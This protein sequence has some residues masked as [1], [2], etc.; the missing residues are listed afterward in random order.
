M[1]DKS[2][3]QGA[4]FF[5]GTAL[6]VYIGTFTPLLSLHSSDWRYYHV[7]SIA[8]GRRGSVTFH[9]KNIKWI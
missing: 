5:Y 6:Y 7:Y 4:L 3:L 8:L 1:S 9:K 2:P